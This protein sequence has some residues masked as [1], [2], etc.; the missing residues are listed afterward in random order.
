VSSLPSAPENSWLADS[1]A[2]LPESQRALLKRC[3]LLSK[4]DEAIVG[5]L[6]AGTD[7]SGDVALA[8]LA[9]YPFVVQIP[10]QPGHYRIRNDMRGVL[11][12]SWWEG[13]P[14]GAVPPELAALSGRLAARLAGRPDTDPD[15]LVGLRLFADPAAGLSQWKKLYSRAD[16]QFDLARCRSLLSVLGWMA[17]VSQDIE[18]AR[19]EYQTY[20]EARSLW[21]DEWYRTV[22]FVLP[23]ASRAAFN[24]VLGGGPGR[25]L[26]VQGHG[27]YGKT[28]HVRWLIA[29]KC[30]VDSPRIPCARIDFDLVDPLAAVREPHLVLLEMADQLDRQLPGDAFGRLV[31]TYAGERVRLYRRQHD[32]GGA[33]EAGD[34]AGN[35]SRSAPADEILRRFAARLAEM[36]PG[37][38]PAVLILD[39]LEVPLHL[40]DM[41]RRPAIEPLLTALAVVQ[42][43]APAVRVVLSGRY[44][45]SPGLRELF[46]DRCERFELP[47]FT[48]DE[49]IEYLVGKRRVPGDLVSA[50]VHA[51]GRVPFSLALLADLI[52]EDPGIS[53][54]VIAEYRGA[55]YAYLV[56]KVVK[57]IREQPVLWVLRYAAIPR[58]FDFDFVRDVLWPRVVAEMD[59]TGGLDDPAGDDLPRQAG[60]GSL[61]VVGPSPQ[62]G[63]QTVRQ[64]WE[65]VRRYANGSSWLGP[66]A[67][68]PDALRLQSEVTRPL[69]ELLHKKKIFKVLHA[70]A[71]AYFLRRAAEIVCDDAPEAAGSPSDRRAELLR[72]AVFHRFQC[73]GAAAGGWWQEQIQAAAA[74]PHARRALAGEL[75]RDPE[76]TDRAGRPV[77]R[78]GEGVLVSEQTLQQARLEFCLACAEL[79]TMAAAQKPKHPLWLDATVALERLESF[80]TA[81]LPG[82]RVAL[83]RAAVAIGTR[84]GG[85][86]G[87][88]LRAALDGPGPAPRERF[89]LAVLDASWLTDAGSP[90][91]DARLAEARRF[92]QEAMAER[93]I[94]QL[95]ASVLVRRLRER[96]ALS[97]AI[98]ICAAAVDD[99]L[100]DGEFTLAAAG[101]QLSS[102]EVERARELAEKV[103]TGG[104]PLAPVARV[105]AARC[106][107]R[108]HRFAAATA[109]TRGVLAALEEAH[110]VSPSGA[111]LRARALLESGEIAATLLR[112]QEGRAAYADAVR[113]F[114][115]T[116]ALTAVAGCHLQEATLL[117]TGLGHLRATGVALDSAERAAPPG[118]DVA[119][120]IQLTRAELFYRL[121][122]RD[123]AE[124]V[125]ARGRSDDPRGSLPTRMAA[126]AVASLAY[127]NRRDRD[128][129]TRQ[130]ADGLRQ[131]TPPTARLQLLT[132]AARCPVLKAGSKAVIALREAVIPAGGWAAEF[133]GLPVQDRI[134]LRLRAAAFDRMLGEPDDARAMLA[135]ALAEIRDCEQPLVWL[136]E[137]LR[138]A[139]LLRAADLAAD[140][141]QQAMRI[142]A[143]QAS[144]CP[145]LAAV[146]VIEHLEAVGETGAIP[147]EDAT[148]DCRR[149]DAWLAESGASAE[150]WWARLFKLYATI[151]TTDQA[152]V[153]SYLQTAAQMYDAAGNKQAAEEVQ[154]RITEPDIRPVS[155]RPK[156]VADVGLRQA[157]VQTQ[158]EQLRFGI[159]LFRRRDPAAGLLRDIIARWAAG[160]AADPYPAELP[161][162]MA[163]RWPEFSRAL[164][165]LL[166]ATELTRRPRRAAEQPDLA[167]CIRDGALQPFPWELAAHP[168]DDG[169][170]FAG[171]RRAYR[172]PA[173]EATDTRLI[174]LVQAGLNLLDNELDVDGVSGPNTARALSALAA[175]AGAPPRR[176]DDPE[177]VQRLHQAR[178]Q[179]ARPGVIVMRPAPAASWHRSLALERR[180]AQAGFDIATI[181]HGHVPALPVL[182]RGVP[183]PLILHIAGGLVAASGGTAV[184]LQDDAGGWGPSGETGLLTP[185][186]LDQALRAMPQDWPAPVVVLDVPL[187]TGQQE[188]ADQLLLRNCFAAD[189]F[190]LGG[191]RGVIGTGLAR[192]KT[193]D[194]VADELVEGLARGDAVGDVVR[195]MRRQAG[196]AGFASF[197]SAMAYAA[198]ALWSSDPSTRLP[199]LGGS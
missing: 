35:D 29:R 116:G 199:T 150:A 104:T 54:D 62:P 51:S 80:P 26:E 96:G 101:M 153:S 9:R 135:L 31:R 180:Y 147:A 177:T 134:T 130:L 102:G 117:M 89:W 90:E 184:D 32:G 107:R 166:D 146:I 143:D 173:S 83:A 40:P 56:E 189:L 170:L 100:G 125:L 169:P 93:G 162:L 118:T 20:V 2:L 172:A 110:D 16:R 61:W 131:V 168:R 164:A 65:Q 15:E 149:A 43:Q 78:W 4:L 81:D 39:T 19:E 87:G 128:Q 23:A 183:P 179:G 82:G 75:A 41:S 46:P 17:T 60:A 48:E 67:R 152:A 28:T 57:R 98:A 8:K 7:V 92:E 85:D 69:R 18:T 66:D 34:A 163:G 176:A 190:A 91:A 122:D 64:V 158:V 79:G 1:L 105:L 36:P 109:G 49:A 161:G 24:A 165:G 94:R 195:E 99:E 71:S 6:T 84:R 141:G 108:Q 145:M 5:E 76:Y 25:M 129:Y 187:P 38:P 21:T 142:V 47:K 111:M 112:V 157:A 139:R 185:P 132:R 3:A 70:D 103:A 55:E 121:G 151:G 119:L 45:L 144:E 188:A 140:A 148:L 42:R 74:D 58:R 155:A 50:A 191:T 181:D 186:D 136:L 138:L 63:E 197:E 106:A 72:E 174:R 37:G 73:E 193:T 154:G 14:P 178:F 22:S 182:L 159:R 68:D 10:D 95:L 114:G 13:Q 30:V 137:A 124:K 59:G 53:P 123:E 194:L 196:P 88:D 77:P 11:L 160:T 97:E 120:L 167:I 12:E 192:R 171:F 127:G 175:D 126:V 86:Y 33:R 44:E 198:T 52:D 156:I 115:E 27:G 133:G 113:L